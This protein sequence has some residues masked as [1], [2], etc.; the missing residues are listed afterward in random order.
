MKYKLICLPSLDIFFLIPACR[1]YLRRKIFKMSFQN[2]NK[3]M[4]LVVGHV[5]GTLAT[6]IK[7]KLTFFLFLNSARWPDI[8]KKF[9]P[10]KPV[11]AA[12]SP[13]KSRFSFKRRFCML[14]PISSGPTLVEVINLYEKSFVANF[15]KTDLAC[16]VTLCIWLNPKLALFIIQ[17]TRY[18]TPS[19]I[20]ANF[21]YLLI[22]ISY[23]P[24]PEALETKGR[25]QFPSSATA[26]EE[27][28]KKKF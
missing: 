6:L 17:L 11:G 24:G 2:R 18:I 27:V 20:L 1:R 13:P 22:Q 15:L 25:P 26:F 28:R 3:W 16:Q 7:F 19:Q 8:L 21:G 10:A 5:S 23:S 12:K 14:W 9:K 4:M